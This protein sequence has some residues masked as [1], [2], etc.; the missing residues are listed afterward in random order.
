MATINVF[1]DG[2]SEKGEIPY[3]ILNPSPQKTLNQLDFEIGALEA[4]KVELQ[5]EINDADTTIT[6]KTT[7]RDEVDTAITAQIA[8]R[9]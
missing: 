3:S 1:D 4:R 6:D 8:K 7:L 2:V 5:S 9:P